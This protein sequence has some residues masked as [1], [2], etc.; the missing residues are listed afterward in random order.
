MKTHLSIIL[1]LFLLIG[2][3]PSN[4]ADKVG[5]YNLIHL[6]V[7][8]K[9]PKGLVD[10]LLF[11]NSEIIKLQT[12]DE[13]IFGEISRLYVVDDL[14]FILDRY[15]GKILI[16]NRDGDF[17]NTIHNIG[18]GPKEYLSIVDFCIN[19][20]EKQIVLLC[21]RPYKIMRYNYKGNFM[22]EANIDMLYLNIAHHKSH[23]YL[24]KSDSYNDCELTIMNNDFSIEQ[25]LIDTRQG[26]RYSGN[27]GTN[28]NSSDG[29]TF[30]RSA[31]NIIYK[32]KDGVISD[33]Y[34]IDFGKDAISAEHS[35]SSARNNRTDIHSITNVV[36]NDKIMLF[37]TNKSLFGYSK[38]TN[39]LYS[40]TSLLNSK[41]GMSLNYFI[42][43]G[44]K[45]QIA[46]VLYPIY[47]DGVKNAAK[48]YPEFKD[49]EALSFAET[50]DDE[51]NPVLL[52]YTFK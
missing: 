48:Q 1:I 12:T 36:D 22:D 33:Q 9:E 21:D 8:D 5:E 6:K 42:T 38:D 32:L 40:Y 23:F 11:E 28:L 14:I 50:L 52:L 44:N 10:T 19:K 7:S 2:C 51:D 27:R 46:Q 31:D 15:L 35:S 20:E 43:A 29:V 16:F 24:K 18:N 3:K 13:S 39:Q 25:E 47:F 26:E 45:D 41:L 30:T 17:I 34:I 49:P 37:T 4:K